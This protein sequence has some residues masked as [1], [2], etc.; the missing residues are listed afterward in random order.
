MYSKLLY[1]QKI[2]DYTRQILRI[3]ES[4]INIKPIVNEHYHEFRHSI[5]KDQRWF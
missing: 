5:I 4:L 3:V 2:Q 1:L